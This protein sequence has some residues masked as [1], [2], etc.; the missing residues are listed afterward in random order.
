M[1]IKIL[2]LLFP[3]IIFAQKQKIQ[4]LDNATKEP[5]QFVE[6][7]Y[8]NNSLFSDKNGNIFID[9]NENKIE[10]LDKNYSPNQIEITSE[11]HIVYLQ[12]NVTELEEMVITKK[13]RIIIKPQSKKI[14]DHFFI[15][16]ERIFLNEIT[17]NTEFQNKYL[18]K[19]SFKSVSEL[20]GNFNNELS[21]RDARN[22]KKTVRNTTQLLRII[23]YDKNMKILFSSKPFEYKTKGKE[24]FEVDIDDEILIVDNPIYLEIKVIG[25]LNEEG[26]FL[27]NVKNI[28]LRPQQ[29]KLPPKEYK[30]RLLVK[31]KNSNS[32]FRDLVKE[33]L[34]L[35]SYINFGFEFE[36]L[37]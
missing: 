35:E 19:L 31:E 29:T 32:K 1:K 14:F 37:E 33:K 2:F 3:I 17:F 24:F 6:L 23:I 10:I 34:M 8:N 7:L 9:F 12:N 15:D 4:L 28:S 13:P 18:R 25:A 16:S 22:A 11:T 30:V 20:Y 26:V 36:D 27:E 21:Q 5:L